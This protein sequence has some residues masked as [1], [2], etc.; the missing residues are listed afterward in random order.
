MY[1]GPVHANIGLNP[2]AMMTQ[3]QEFEAVRGTIVFGWGDSETMTRFF[4]AG[5][6]SVAS[7]VHWDCSSQ[8]PTVDIGDRRVVEDG[9]VQDLL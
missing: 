3:H 5:M 2:R 1:H 4:G 6:E 8:R 9:W 7:P